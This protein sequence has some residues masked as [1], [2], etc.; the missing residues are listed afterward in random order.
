MLQSRWRG[1]LSVGIRLAIAI[2]IVGLIISDVGWREIESTLRRAEAS[3]L[4]L[5]VFAL[6]LETI[7]KAWNWTR[8]LD[9]LDCSTLGKRIR[10]LRVY[11]IA[12]LM[13]SLLPSTASTDAARVVLAHRTLGGRP[14]SH[15]AAIIVQNVVGWVGGCIL[16]LVCVA[17][18]ASRAQ[19]PTYLLVAAL[20][21]A[22]VAVAAVGLHLALRR[23]RWLLVLTLRRVLRRHWLGLRRAIRRFADALLVFERAHVRFAPRVLVAVAGAAFSALVFAA[24]AL[25]VGV[26][27]PLAVWGAVVPLNSLVG[28]LPISISGLGGA[29]AAHISMLVPFTVAVPEAF[30]VSAIYAVLNL[31]FTVTCG[32]VAWTLGPSVLA[33]ELQ[34]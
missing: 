31:M 23:Y 6:M 25:A 5:A 10:L 29:Q 18:L 1:A 19:A 11:L 34:G 33:N 26:D 14:S 24:V 28:L 13:G 20:L 12:A 4:L 27:L 3:W 2:V 7:A 15:A 22:G 16:G 21:F 8:L 30:A 9:S 32:A 17:W